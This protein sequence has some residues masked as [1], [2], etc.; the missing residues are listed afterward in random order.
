MFLRSVASA[1][2]GWSATTRTWTTHRR[3]LTLSLLPVSSS[4]ERQHIRRFAG[5]QQLLQ[6]SSERNDFPKAKLERTD[7][8]HASPEFLFKPTEEQERVIQSRGDIK[9]NAVAGSGKT[10]TL[11]QYAAARPYDRILYVAFNNSVKKEAKKNSRRRRL[12]MAEKEVRSRSRQPM[13]WQIKESRECLEG[14][15]SPRKAGTS[16]MTSSPLLGII[17][18]GT[19]GWA[20]TEN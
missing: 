15:S 10:A 17:V 16:H 2:V 13:L 8:D 12:F 11:L 14:R 7:T 6:F 18:W 1:S 20:D 4:K 3:A 9:V 5:P 19:A